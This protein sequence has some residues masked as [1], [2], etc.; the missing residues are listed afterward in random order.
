MVGPEE[1]AA[2]VRR[3]M[4]DTGSRVVLVVEDLEL[5]GWIPRRRVLLITG[6]KTTA[7]SR[8]IMDEP[9][10][11]VSPGERVWSA[12][13]RMLRFDE[14]YAPVVE[15][16]TLKGL[17]GLEH[18]IGEY[19]RRGGE[20]LSRVRLDE[21][22][23]RDPVTASPEDFVSSIW[24]IMAERKYAGIPV[25]DSKGRL[26]G[27]ITQYDLLRKGYARVELVSESGQHRGPRVRE[28][29]TYTVHY[30]YPWSS[31]EEAARIMVE[32]GVGR[33]PVVDGEEARRLVGIVDREDVVRVIF[34]W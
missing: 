24:R 11:T 10:V 19:L 2:A 34:G 13:E 12:V 5:L 33:V 31:L 30:L 4:R 29:M 25:V 28:A 9:P 27:I 8:D 22:M 6:R 17:I 16:K 21:V 26:V 14:W 1:S 3:L 7:K 15:G 20:V 32:R 23:T 18:V